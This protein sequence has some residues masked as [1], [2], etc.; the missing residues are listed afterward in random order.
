MDGNSVS[1]QLV[2][3]IAY[4]NDLLALVSKL[5]EQALQ[6]SSE[7][8]SVEAQNRASNKE[9]ADELIECKRK[10]NIAQ[11]IAESLSSKART[12]RLENEQLSGELE[13][14]RLKKHDD[15][16]SIRTHYENEM[17]HV[18]L[19]LT[20]S[21]ESEATLL[22]DIEGLRA[23]VLLL[24]TKY[25]GAL[26]EA[27]SYKIATTSLE[28]EMKSARQ[29]IQTLTN[30]LKESEYK[31][32]TALE[33]RK[34]LERQICDMSR[35]EQTAKDEAMQYKYKYDEEI[36]RN[37]RYKEKFEKQ[38]S[39]IDSCMKKIFTLEN[40]CNAFQ[41]NA[42]H[43]KTQIESQQ[44]Q[45]ITLR[46]EKESV[47][48]EKESLENQ[49]SAERES[50]F[51][52][53]GTMQSL[54]IKC[55]SLEKENTH[56][57]REMETLQ[58]E[59]ANMKR[60]NETKDENILSYEKQLKDTQV[61][62]TT[63]RSQ[64]QVQRA[65]QEQHL[66]VLKD[67]ISNAHTQRI[68]TQREMEEIKNENEKNVE[69]LESLLLQRNDHFIKTIDKT[70]Q[71]MENASKEALELKSRMRAMQHELFTL[72]SKC[73]VSLHP[74]T[75]DWRGIYG[76]LKTKLTLMEDVQN[77]RNKMNS[78]WNP[79]VNTS[80]RETPRH[81]QT[82]SIS[83]H[84]GTPSASLVDSRYIAPSSSP[85]LVSGL[86]SG[87]SNNDGHNARN[88]TLHRDADMSDRPIDAGGDDDLRDAVIALKNRHMQEI[89]V[90]DG[91]ANELKRKIAK[92]EEEKTLLK[93]QYDE[94]CSAHNFAI[95]D[96]KREQRRIEAN[97]DVTSS[98]YQ[99]KCSQLRALQNEI[100]N[101]EM[102]YRDT[103][104]KLQLE[105]DK[106]KQSFLGE[107]SDSETENIDKAVSKAL[108]ECE[109]AWTSKYDEQAEV[110]RTTK[111]QTEQQTELIKA[112]SLQLQKQSKKKAGD[113][114]TEGSSAQRT[115]P[116]PAQ[117]ASPPMSLSPSSSEGEGERDGFDNNGSPPNPGDLSRSYHSPENR[118]D[119]LQYSRMVATVPTAALNASMTS[120][121]G[122]KDVPL[123][124]QSINEQKNAS[125]TNVGGSKQDSRMKVSDFLAIETHFKN[126]ISQ[127]R[128]ELT[129]AQRNNEFYEKSLSELTSS[130][131][132]QIKQTEHYET[133]WVNAVQEIKE[134][135][136]QIKVKDEE[137]HKAFSSL[138]DANQH[139]Q[140]QLQ[141]AQQLLG[142]VTKQRDALNETNNFLR[143]Q[144][145]SVN[146]VKSESTQDSHTVFVPTP[147][148]PYRN[149][150]SPNIWHAQT[151]HFP[152]SPE[153]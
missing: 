81:R 31:N 4:N 124:R 143:I 7:L 52:K 86:D 17:K 123:L 30:S 63:V 103:E 72:K 55:T 32:T 120:P 14:A 101:I 126:T 94:E 11:Q 6:H 116:I 65:D 105:K 23:K 127:Y 129:Q 5:E 12:Y 16:D 141:S 15:A 136:Y 114:D 43:L 29:H 88:D 75:A 73:E 33:T 22:T 56:L 2:G 98:Q 153:T 142:T 70:Q 100:M 91:Y 34:S 28:N 107:K 145:E 113:N 76:Q 118:V 119:G 92:L 36:S 111:L 106:N 62:L 79:M 104:Q 20:R 49:L 121:S 95:I 74:S 57:K 53:N 47:V 109:L 133:L 58:S 131:E 42:S 138:Y 122:T 135:D 140:K 102:K 48:R 66:Q 152:L 50:S 39:D 13:K 144:L 132:E 10:L 150:G 59:I 44:L 61:Q 96:L 1:K 87:F 139:Y 112:L 93:S 68:Q 84:Y 134:R 64:G 69:A 37:T 137:H 149:G 128:Y 51:T 54:N 130:M 19:Q 9:L 125:P 21:K 45:L 147:I 18:S 151:P 82:T 40:S 27:D 80:M 46:S 38:A 89:E 24:Q 108:A 90:K 110:L 97:T 60:L 146:Q 115:D 99:E 78:Q 26:S 35:D 117:P 71:V 25:D 41:S 83:S 148:Q 67:E 85:E 3:Q 77:R 8:E